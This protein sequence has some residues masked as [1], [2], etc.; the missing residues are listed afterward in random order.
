MALLQGMRWN[1]KRGPIV[2]II[3]YLIDLSFCLVQMHNCGI[4]VRNCSELSKPAY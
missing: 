3:I 2:V 1:T 4:A